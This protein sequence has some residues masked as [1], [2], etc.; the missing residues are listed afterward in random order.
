MRVK[1]I[2]LC[3]LICLWYYCFAHRGWFFWS[4]NTIR[5]ANSRLS[6]IPIH[7][8]DTSL[9]IVERSEEFELRSHSNFRSGS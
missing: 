1:Y 8:L 5:K 9:T 4:C 6:V 3:I 7:V 2:K